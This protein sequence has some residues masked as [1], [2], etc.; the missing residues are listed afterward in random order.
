MPFSDADS[1]L[2]SSS[3]RGFQ[4]G[5][6]TEAFLSCH[7]SKQLVRRT[8]QVSCT[9]FCLSQKA[10]SRYET[11][12]MYKADFFAATLTSMPLSVSQSL[13]LQAP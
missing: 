11:S 2:G 13:Q 1:A 4:Y 9:L 10:H 8:C 7:N 3:G 12:R 5:S 6:Q